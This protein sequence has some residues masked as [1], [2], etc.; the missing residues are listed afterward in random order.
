MIPIMIP[1]MC[2]GYSDTKCAR[3]TQR[4]AFTVVSVVSHRGR[5]ETNT[6][7][8]SFDKRA[9]PFFGRQ[10]NWIR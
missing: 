6:Y 10:A 8:V 3:R 2:F 1:F 9:E 7:T 5:R 4:A